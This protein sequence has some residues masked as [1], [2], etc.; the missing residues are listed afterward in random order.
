MPNI[1]T[2]SGSPTE[3]GSTEILLGTVVKGI[4]SAL[5]EEIKTEL[6][7]LNDYKY[8]PCQACGK[9][10]EPEYC[11]FHD[12]IYPIY[13]KLI[14]CDIVLLGTPVYFDSVSAQSKSFIDRCNCLR[15]ADFENKGNHPFKKLIERKRLGG[16]IIVGGY[17]GEFELAR[18]VIAGFFKWVEVTN[19]GLVT[20]ESKSWEK[21][22]VLRNAEKL[23][24][25]NDLG[26][27]IAELLTQ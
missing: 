15:P 21:G 23:A 5:K 17:R 19:C 24:E 12:E 22:A 2:I 4:A 6:I 11:F 26:K 16:M 25:A 7:R 9:S 27:K 10:P 20:Y 1:L 13:G 8:I 14:S 18:K 3:N